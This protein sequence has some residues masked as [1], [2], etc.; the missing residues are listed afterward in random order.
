MG[1]GRYVVDAVVLEG[2][3]P[4]ELAR[5]HGISRSWIYELVARYRQGGYAA[6]AARSKR[7]HSCAH[8]TP[9][10]IERAV[11]RLRTEL[12]ARGHDG[13]PHT[14]ASHLARKGEGV[15]SL[16][17]IWRILKR[18]GLITP[19]PQ[20]RPRSSLIRFAAALPNELWQGDTT[21]WSLAGGY[22]GMRT[23]V[24]NVLRQAS[25]MS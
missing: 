24:Q 4:R 22:F 8:Q 2:R 6:I 23:P 14:I 16:A 11:V 1:L 3:S 18:R 20:K 7:P 25:G 19:Q 5:A 17:T 10:K 12:I 9:R 21:H 13:G 15:P